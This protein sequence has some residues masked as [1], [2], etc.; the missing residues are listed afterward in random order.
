VPE[1]K[2]TTQ[3][4]LAVRSENPEDAGK[5]AVRVYQDFVGRLRRK[6]PAT[7]NLRLKVQKPEP[8][9]DTAGVFEIWSDLRAEVPTDLTALGANDHRD[10]WRTILKHEFN[11][12][13]QV[14]HELVYHTASRVETTRHVLPQEDAPQ[15]VVAPTEQKPKEMIA[16]KV[17][18]GGQLFDVE[19]PKN[20]NLLDGVNDKGVA[21]KW[22][23][24]SG[25]CDTCKVRVLKGMENLSPPN[26]AEKSMLGDLV[27]QGYRLSCQV[28]ASGPC[29]I[30][31]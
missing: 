8:R 28:T 7:R 30:Q 9:K 16:V 20:E 18:L 13:C 14:N 2:Y 29:E 6:A 22:D 21:V 23:C 17:T 31:H 24:K 11:V 12:A 19:I 4:Y 5:A 1:T 3:I 26:D 15:A 27:N 25:V 10:A